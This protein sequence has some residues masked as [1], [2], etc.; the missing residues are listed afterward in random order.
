MAV[1]RLHLILNITFA[2]NIAI[3]LIAF[4]L[5]YLN[6]CWIYM[7]LLTIIYYP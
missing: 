3:P 7:I 5:I 4:V 6:E 2:K 1:H